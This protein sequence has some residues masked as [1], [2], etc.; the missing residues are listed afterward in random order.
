MS[1]PTNNCWLRRPEYRFP[2]TYRDHLLFASA[3]VQSQFIGG[4]D[5]ARLLYFSELCFVLK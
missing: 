5:V 1:S 2:A 3:C 4:V